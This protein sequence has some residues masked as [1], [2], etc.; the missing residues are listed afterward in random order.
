MQISVP[1]SSKHSRAQLAH[2]II[3]IDHSIEA[4]LPLRC[5][6][7]VA[8]VLGLRVAHLVVREASNGR[9]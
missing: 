9:L 2:G 5:K 3:I 8:V 1:T 7:E 4:M 6:D